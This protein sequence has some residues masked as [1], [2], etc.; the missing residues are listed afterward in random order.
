MCCCP[1]DSVLTGFCEPIAGLF[2]K[3]SLDIHY[4]RWGLGSQPL[5]K[6]P[7]N[8]VFLSF[9]YHISIFEYIYMIITR[10]RVTLSIIHPSIKAQVY[11]LGVERTIG[12][13]LGSED[14]KDIELALDIRIEAEFN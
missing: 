1:K 11:I 14:A 7:V 3:N 4:S 9:Y 8:Q 12:H 2:I 6:T 13:F 5:V 10:T